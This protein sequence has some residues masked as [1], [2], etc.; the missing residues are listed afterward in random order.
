MTAGSNDARASMIIDRTSLLVEI[1]AVVTLGACEDALRA[2]G[3]TLDVPTVDRGA[4]VGSWLASGARG[5]RDPWSDPA[6]HLV[7]GL[8]A[9]M[10][11]GSTLSIRPTPRRAVG[12]DLIALVV[13]MAD[14]FARIER[15]WL[16][17]HSLNGDRARV[18]PLVADRNPP[19]SEGES[20]LLVEIERALRA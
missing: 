9:T 16:R 4:S 17:V 13:G 5:A 15:A 12:P 11:D 20:R 7:A 18:H 19:L 2:A 1:A 3:L 14:R 8:E 6:D 10:N